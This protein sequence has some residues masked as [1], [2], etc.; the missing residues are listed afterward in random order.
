MSRGWTWIDEV[1]DKL[2]EADQDRIMD[3]RTPIL[4]HLAAQWSE[5]QHTEEQSRF[6]RQSDIEDGRDYEFEDEAEQKAHEAIQT[7]KAQQWT[8]Q[9]NMI[10]SQINE[11]GARMMRPYEHWNEDERYM[12]YMERDRD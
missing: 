3:E 2:P 7:I 12:A 10:E 6:S 11:L 4:N 9:L 1:M 8:A 5:M